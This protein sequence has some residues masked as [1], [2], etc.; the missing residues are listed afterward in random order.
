MTTQDLSVLFDRSPA[1]HVQTS[2]A[3]EAA[4]LCA[5]V[6]LVT[7]PFSLTMAVCVGLATVGLVL[8]VLG[9]A[10]ASRPDAAGG[11][12]AALGVV[13]SLVTLAVVGLRYAGL[14]TAFG[15]GLVPAL[16]DGLRALNDLLPRP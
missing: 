10:R 5:L 14:D 7:A 1:R 9:M 3:A 2:A 13:L 15:D 4:F 8:G 11:L 6:A 12:L 16:A